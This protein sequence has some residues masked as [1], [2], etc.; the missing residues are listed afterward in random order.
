MHEPH[1]PRQTHSPGQSRCPACQSVPMCAKPHEDSEDESDPLESR[2]LSFLLPL[3]V[4]LALL[5]GFAYMVAGVGGAP[6]PRGTKAKPRPAPLVHPGTWELDWGGTQY[7][8]TLRADGG[9][10]CVDP[11]CPR[12]NRWEGN[13]HW[14]CSRGLLTVLESSDGGVTWKTWTA[15]AER[16][17]ERAEAKGRQAGGGEL[18]L[19]ADYAGLS[20]AA[21]MRLHV[22]R[23][24]ARR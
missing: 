9:Y 12:L 3:L 2:A 20:V 16:G 22:K 6:A 14:D 21:R 19:A 15:V 7:L 23:E 8:L 4:A 17:R 18:I 10:L 13:W 1:S 24:V 5:A 11:A